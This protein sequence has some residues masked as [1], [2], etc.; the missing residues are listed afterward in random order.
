MATSSKATSSKR[1]LWKGAIS[2]GLVHIPVSLHPA[3]SDH[4][5]DFDWLDKRTLDPVGYKRIN[6]RTGK[7]ITAEHIVKGLNIGGDEYIVLSPDEIEAAYP[8]TTQTI[9][10]ESFVPVNAVPFVYLD[11]P[12]Y[13]APVGRGGKVYALLR[14]VLLKTQ[15]IGIAR[16]VI[17]TRQHLA[18]LVATDTALVLNL[19]RWNDQ[20]RSMADLD[21]P[22][23][24]VKGAG[25][26]ER[27]M[28][29]ATQLVEDMSGDWQP[30]EFTDSFKDQVL[31]LV[32]RKKKAGKTRTVT[33]VEA[34][35]KEETGGAQIYDLADLLKRSLGKRG[36][37]DTDTGKTASTRTAAPRARPAAKSASRT[38]TKAPAKPATRK[39]AA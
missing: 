24:G 31:A 12:Y 28:Q 7:E 1:A 32:E 13:I 5:L 8:K 2:F 37:A 10:I 3:T 29:M 4:G 25:I 26:S 9:E 22:A 34:V 38:A 19:L 30:D 17:Q 35:E 11:R 6:K 39:R 27:E 20:L 18:A 21:L 23:K 15:R 14:E 33:K 16:V 36:G